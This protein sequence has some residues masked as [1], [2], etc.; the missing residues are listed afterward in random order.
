MTLPRVTILA[1]GVRRDGEEDVPRGEVL[2][3][4]VRLDRAGTTPPDRRGKLHA[5]LM[6][7]LQ[8]HRLS[9]PAEVSP[10]L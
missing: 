3:L 9:P 2:D 7:R 1:G 10:R 4:R 8:S 5:S 6:H